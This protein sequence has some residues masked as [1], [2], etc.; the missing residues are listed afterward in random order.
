VRCYG[1]CRPVVS[2]S[3]R[4][5]TEYGDL[6]KLWGLWNARSGQGLGNNWGLGNNSCGAGRQMKTDVGAR[7]VINLEITNN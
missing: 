7:L 6:E 4:V 2:Q 1:P 3:A 5:S